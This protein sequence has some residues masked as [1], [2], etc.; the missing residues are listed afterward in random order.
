MIC[1]V[2]LNTAI[3]K[4][5]LSP[6]FT[7]GAHVKA[8]IRDFLPAGKG[9]N[10]ARG[11]ARLGVDAACCGFAGEREMP[12]FLE[13]LCKEGVKCSLTACKGLTRTNTTIID[14]C[15]GTCTHIREPGFAAGKDELDELE[16]DIKRVLQCDAPGTVAFC[17][18][19]PHGMDESRL[20][21]LISIA[22]DS[23]SRVVLDTSGEAGRKALESGLVNVI[24]PNL[25]ELELYLMR[26]TAPGEACAAA[27]ELL[28]FADTV[29]LTL[30]EEGACMI[31]RS[32]SVRAYCRIPQK[33]VKNT[34]GC[35]DAFLAGWLSGVER[36][37]APPKSLLKGVACATASAC[38]DTTVG[39]GPEQAEFFLRRCELAAP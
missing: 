15:G 27:G 29:L 32:E 11:L 28:R 3:D 8:E 35:G 18:G 6:G 9:I 5:L 37:L 17:G 19:L 38:S 22:A 16:R 30:G 13:S 1:T 23:G 25:A 4:V 36:G 34:V 26:R 33:R 24:K 12:F 14:P 20:L 7:A 31:D 39:Y 21:D 2:T 10:V